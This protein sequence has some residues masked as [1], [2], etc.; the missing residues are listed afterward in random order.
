MTANPVSGSKTSASSGQKGPARKGNSPKS[1]GK[2]KSK[3]PGLK[4]KAGGD[5]RFPFLPLFTVWVIAVIVLICLLFWGGNGSKIPSRPTASEITARRESTHSPN[6]SP[7]SS[8]APASKIARAPMPS[9][10]DA[11]PLTAPSEKGPNPASGSSPKAPPAAAGPPSASSGTTTAG[12]P[13]DPSAPAHSPSRSFSENQSTAR[14]PIAGNNSPAPENPS[15]SLKKGSPHKEAS[16]SPEPVRAREPEPKEEL[17]VALNSPP[18]QPKVP[19]PPVPDVSPPV[20]R[21]AIV[22]DDCGQDLEAAK[23]ILKIPLQITFSILPYQRYSREIAQLANSQGREVIVHVPM[24][25]KD[26]PKANPGAGALLLS[27]SSGDIQ[28][29][30]KDILESNPYATGINNHMGSRFTENAEAMGIVLSEARDRSIY[31]FDSYTSPKSVGYSLAQQMNIPT[32]RRDVFLDHVGTEKFVRSQI[33]QLIRKAK[34]QGTAIAIGHPHDYTLRVLSQEAQ[35]F[36][37][38]GVSVV[39]LKTLIH[40]GPG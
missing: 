33:N 15:E 38:E 39:P 4:K 30:L 23:R 17:I 32:G 9:R 22:I 18:P 13:D 35:R 37:K 11:K 34:V 7:T 12:T 24:E 25:P 3:K 10:Q 6:S 31:F 28:K 5:R 16:S 21:V 26:Y 20:A 36:Q 27:M 19:M 2:T 14:A 40:S 8:A 1:A 29:T